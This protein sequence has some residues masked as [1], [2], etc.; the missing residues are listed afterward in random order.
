MKDL[1]R[2][3]KLTLKLLIPLCLDIFTIYLDLLTRSIA[4]ALYS[5]VMGT[6]L[7]FLCMEK[8]LTANIYQLSQFFD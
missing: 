1:E 7:Q 6:L 2:S 4:A 3:K 8:V 5:F